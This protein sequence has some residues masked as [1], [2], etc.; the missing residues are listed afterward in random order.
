[1]SFVTHASKKPSGLSRGNVHRIS[2]ITVGISTVIAIAMGALLASQLVAVQNASAV[3]STTGSDHGHTVTVKISH[4][5]S[6]PGSD[7]NPSSGSHSGAPGEYC[8]YLPQP[9]Y[10]SGVYK[11]PSGGEWYLVSCY[12]G[13]TYLGEAEVWLPGVPAGTG[14]ILVDPRAIAATAESS[15]SLPSPVIETNPPK[16]TIVNFATWFWVSSSLWHSFAATAQLDG[17]SATAVATPVSVS[18]STG[19][20][21]NLTCSGPGTPYRAEDASTA[22]AQT[23]Q[24]AQT[25]AC[26]HEY[27]TPSTVPGST[28]EAAGGFLVTA[29]VTW[30]VSWSSHGPGVSEGGELSPLETSSDTRLRVEQVE[31]VGRP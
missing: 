19:D 2:S 18:F 26:S 4:T 31:S 17:V 7:H 10:D 24:T 14:A 27:M 23:T 6:A 28:S 8:Y 12:D 25:T 29:T 5:S 20:G 13:S 9:H 15:I 22:T 1:M 21:G 11:P 30:D 16:F 3:G